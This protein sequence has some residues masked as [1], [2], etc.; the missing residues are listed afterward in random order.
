MI[1]AKEFFISANTSS[2]GAGSPD[3]YKRFDKRFN[4]L[5]SMDFIGS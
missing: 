4:P 2:S 3:T 1:T 5:E